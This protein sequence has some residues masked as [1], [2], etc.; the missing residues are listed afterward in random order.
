[1]VAAVLAIDA[2]VHC[3]TG[4]SEMDVLRVH[5]AH[6]VHCRTGSSEMLLGQVQLPV[7]V[8][9]GAAHLVADL[10]QGFV[11]GLDGQ[12]DVA[13]VLAPLVGAQD[14]AHDFATAIRTD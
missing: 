1:M 12:L 13:H 14:V 4:S 8:H 7:T 5:A 10:G 9:I 2:Q 11:P 6:K 3:R